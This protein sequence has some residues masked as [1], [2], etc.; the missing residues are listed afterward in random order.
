MKIGFETS[1]LIY[2]EPTGVAR[3][4]VSILNEL[5]KS[6][7]EHDIKLLYKM[8]RLKYREHWYQSKNLPTQVYQS[9][10]WPL[11]KNY[12]LI[13]GLDAYVPNWANTKKIITIHDILPLLSSNK[14]ISPDNF[15]DKKLNQYQT[16]VKYCDL[17][18]T[19]SD[20]TR[21]DVIDFFK[22]PQSKVTTV[23]PGVDNKIFYQRSRSS[24]DNV[25]SKFGLDGEYLIFVGSISS[26]KN[27]ESLVQA[28][29]N[30]KA[31]NQYDLV[32]VGSLSYLGEKTI[33]AI[34]KNKL[35]KKV[36]LLKYA[37]D[38]DLPVLYSGARA[39]VFPTLYEG[40]GFPIIEAMLC[41]LPVLTSNLGSAPEVANG[42]AHLVDPHKIESITSGIDD[43]V[44]TEPDEEKILQA[45]KY[46]K[47][48][49]W[50]SCL[51]NMLNIYKNLTNK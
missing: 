20:N 4:I 39:L 37:S 46:A 24:I 23:Y 44:R 47:Q 31:N 6:K 50:K 34:R 19:V 29:A 41:Q 32:L 42:F 7:F 51:N 36:K 16:V 25:K 12:D 49:T 28:Y 40:F 15:S 35:E 43:L 1:S 38:D 33:E 2:Q 48:F 27:T 11:N 26:R 30:S 18:I 10:I 22:I 45:V 5:Q 21:Q 9:N 8:S 13:H 3:Y 14:Q 17:I